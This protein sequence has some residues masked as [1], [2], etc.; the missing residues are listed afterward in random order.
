MDNQILTRESFV[1]IINNNSDES[2]N[3]GLLDFLKT[4]A[5]KEWDS[6]KSKNKNIKTGLETADKNLKGFTLAKL[7][8]AS[9][10]DGIRQALCD[11]GNALWDSKQESLDDGK[12]IKRLQMGLEEPEVDVKV[13]KEL[14]IK[15]KTLKDSLSQFENK[16]GELCDGDPKL[17]KWSNLLK[18]EIRNIV[19]KMII[20]AYEKNASKKETEKI[21]KYKDNL[22]KQKKNS[23]KEIA[24]ADKEATQEQ[25]KKVKELEKERTDVLNAMGVKPLSGMDG[26]KAV[27]TLFAGFKN[28]K[29]QLEKEGMKIGESHKYSFSEL[30]LEGDNKKKTI[31]IDDVKKIISGD[32]MFG[33]SLISKDDVKKTTIKRILK[34]TNQSL[35]EYTNII[36]SNNLKDAIKE[37]ASDAIHAMFVGIVRTIYCALTGTNPDDKTLDVLARCAIS[38]DKTIGF[39]LPMMDEDDEEKG[40][41]FTELM[42]IIKNPSGN[43]VNK[44]EKDKIKDKFTKSIDSIFKAVVDKAK[45]IKET[46]AKE[47]EKEA[48]DVDNE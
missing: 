21:K 31:S 45:K 13:K 2:L 25:E 8:N 16:I 12:K 4:L 47:D 35:V 7:K 39:G 41:V 27:D 20:D 44:I 3:E 29:D 37:T 11:Y 43:V 48:K 1:G 33:L 6:V 9:A 46:K 15:D 10:C 14:N 36:Q 42:G 30:I 17:K 19:N 23:E 24:D 34:M 28:I 38:S 18:Y 5:S 22:D 26:E 40:N 32:T